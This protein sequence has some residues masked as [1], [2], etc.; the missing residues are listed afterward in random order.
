MSIEMLGILAYGSL[1][2]DAGELE[3]YII[4]RKI[5]KTPFK[6]EFARKSRTRGGAPTLAIV[7]SG[8][9][10]V[11]AQILVLR[12]TIGI[13]D[14]KNML[15]RREIHRENEKNLVYDPTNKSSTIKILSMSDFRGIETVLYTDPKPNIEDLNAKNLAMLAIESAKMKGKEKLD[16]ISYLIE[17]KNCGIKTP[18]MEGYEQ[19]ILDLMRPRNLEEALK[20]IILSLSQTW[21]QIIEEKAGDLSSQNA[22]RNYPCVRPFRDSLN[23]KIIESRKKWISYLPESDYLGISSNIRGDMVLVF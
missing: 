17:A 9:S 15:Y 16:G 20:A 2:K 1:I 6:V 18:L 19:A 8:G 4:Q 7:Q 11:D 21:T 13:Q 3:P 5:V 10:Y 14:A 23:L 12:E 22:N